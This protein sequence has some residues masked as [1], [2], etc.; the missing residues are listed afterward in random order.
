MD[1]FFF[2]VERFVVMLE[3]CFVIEDSV[4]GV[5]VGCLVGMIVW[6]FVGGGY[7][8]VGYGE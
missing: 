8:Y 2:V 3:K 5:K 7:S 4:N 6:G 1:L